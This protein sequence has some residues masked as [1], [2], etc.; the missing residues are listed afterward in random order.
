MYD[1]SEIQRGMKVRTHDGHVLGKIIAMTE[2]Q[3]VIEK[4]RLRHHDFLVDLKDVCEVLHGQVVLNHGQDSLFYAPKRISYEEAHRL[5]K[6]VDP[7][8]SH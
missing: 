1:R 4:G 3:L 5:E 6:A 2:D 7:A 8:P